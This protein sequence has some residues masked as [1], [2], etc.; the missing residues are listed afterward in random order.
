MARLPPGLDCLGHNGT[1]NLRESYERI[2]QDREV[3]EDI[4]KN[5]ITVNIGPQ[6]DNSGSSD[7]T[8]LRLGSMQGEDRKQCLDIMR[9]TPPDVAAHY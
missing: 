2:L 7:Q 1:L 3:T 5:T 8:I 6:Y 9:L 4:S